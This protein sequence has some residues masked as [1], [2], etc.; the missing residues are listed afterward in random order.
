[1]DNIENVIMN[2][3]EY[4]NDMSENKYDNFDISKELIDRN[5]HFKKIMNIF[6][7][8]YKAECVEYDNGNYFII[9]INDNLGYYYIGIIITEEMILYALVYNNLNELKKNRIFQQLL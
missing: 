6:I 4:I 3:I 2:I 1:M 5:H 7:K 8:Y 9:K